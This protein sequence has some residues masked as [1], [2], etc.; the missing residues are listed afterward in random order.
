MWKFIKEYLPYY[1]HYKKEIFLAVIGMIMVSASTAAIAYII[2]PVLDKIFIEKNE[3]LLYLLPIGIIIIYFI[4]GVGRYIQTYYVTYI[5][6]D[7][8]RQIRDKFL[9]YILTFDMDY[10]KK[11]HSGEL[12][13]RIINDINR[14][15]SAISHDLANFIRDI[16]MALFLLG[17]VIYQSPKLAFFAIIIMP[18]IIYPIGKIAKKLK[19]LSKQSQAKT[20]DLNKH[21]SEIFKNIETI[22]AYNAKIFEYEKFKEENLKYLKINL[23][24]IRTSALLN[25][26]LELMNAT[27][28]AIVIIVGG[29][30]V[31]T[32]QMSVGAFFSFMT[33][34]FMMTEPIK[35]A[36]NTY[37]NLQNAIA[38]NE[39]LKEI[40]HLKPQIVSGD[41]KLDN[42]E[43]IEFKNVSLKYGNNTALQNITY[44]A[45]KPVKVG[46]VGDS[47]GGKSSFVS[48]IM[49]FYDPSS[50]EILINGENMKRYSLEDLREKIAYIPQNVHIFNDTIAA[51]VAYG[52]EID[53][54]KVKN[55]LKKANLLEFVESL[56]EGINT[57]LLENGSNLSGGQKQRIAIARALYKDP[58]VLILDEA[59]SAL[60][61]KSEAVIMDA[62]NNLK[63]MIVFIIAHRL[64]T[65]DNADEILV[66]KN[67][68][69]VCKGKKEDLLEK[70]EEFK[71]L[72]QKSY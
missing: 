3:H 44:T 37:S 50:G 72:Y 63:D 28:A 69:I 43:K 1:K 67:G 30:E 12:V 55:A 4:K 22:K 15:Q 34:L 36:S 62:I 29:H 59:T 2:K 16:L 7:V 38:A 60:D 6:E 57:V 45:E 66:F 9:N 31:I 8:V 21:L 39:R 56:P 47:G 5:G 26:I 58:D 19:N 27:V 25:P 18:L 49:R 46:L 13:S 70:C 42:I 40:F 52:K 11:T 54:E 41:K 35:R 17:V 68:Q 32:G 61:N 20:A 33:A 10:F 14:I 48:L 65:I 51:N 24:T 23:K 71:K 64:H 53:E